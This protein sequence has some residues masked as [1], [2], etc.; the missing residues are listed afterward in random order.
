ML[1]Q[2]E[3]DKIKKNFARCAK[4]PSDENIFVRGTGMISYLMSSEPLV[5]SIIK[6]EGLCK[7]HRKNLADGATASISDF[8]HPIFE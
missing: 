4:C 2:K 5:Q 8:S 6:T 1:N 3:A 7:D